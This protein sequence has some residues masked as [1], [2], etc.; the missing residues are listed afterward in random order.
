MKRYETALAAGLFASVA[1]I[2]V[3]VSP[4][5]DEQAFRDAQRRARTGAAAVVQYEHNP[6]VARWGEIGVNL[7]AVMAY[8]PGDVEGTTVLSP[9]GMMLAVPHDEFDA[10]MRRYTRSGDWRPGASP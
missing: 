3:A 5:P 6:V 9:G 1:A 7:H 10:V 8:H 2:S 4:Q